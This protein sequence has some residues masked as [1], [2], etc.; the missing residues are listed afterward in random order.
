MNILI[1]IYSYIHNQ[2]LVDR[3]PDT[4]CVIAGCEFNQLQN[5]II[6]IKYVPE[7]D[8]FK[9][10]CYCNHSELTHFHKVFDQDIDLSESL[11]RLI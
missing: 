8:T 5:E 2:F 11:V 3:A 6:K 4:N 9:L 1:Y 10:R 7:N